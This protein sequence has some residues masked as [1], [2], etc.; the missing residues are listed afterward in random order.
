MSS[1]SGPSAFISRIIVVSHGDF[2]RGVPRGLPSG[3]APATNRARPSSRPDALWAF[4]LVQPSAS[5]DAA[6]ASRRGD[7]EHGAYLSGSALDRTASI[8]LRSAAGDGLEHWSKEDIVASLKT[9]RNPHSAVSGPMG[10]V[11]EH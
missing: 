8:N 6:I 5:I 4:A 10:E 2:L 3:R 11:V 7:A 1:G 9:R